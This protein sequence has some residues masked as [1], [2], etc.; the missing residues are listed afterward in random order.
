MEKTQL[1]VKMR[2]VL[3]IHVIVPAIQCSGSDIVL[4]E[5][6]DVT[7]GADFILTHAR[8]E[9]QKYT[10]VIGCSS[11][12]NQVPKSSNILTFKYTLETHR[13]FRHEQ[14]GVKTKIT[15]YLNGVFFGGGTSKF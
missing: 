7:D 8:F 15:L 14:T 9:Q 10:T 5:I 2:P 1:T 4:N 3:K 13:I 11:S 12:T 6:D